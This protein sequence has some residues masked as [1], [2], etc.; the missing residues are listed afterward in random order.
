LLRGLDLRLR[1]ET[2]LPINVIED[3]LTAVARGT[4][5]VLEAFSEYRKVLF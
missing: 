2:K 1:H 4:G 5:R 3:P